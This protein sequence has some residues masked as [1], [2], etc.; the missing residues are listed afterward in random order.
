MIGH[1][2]VHIQ[3]F[4]TRSPDYRNLRFKIIPSLVEGPLPVRVLFPP[5][6][7]FVVYGNNLPISWRQENE[8]MSDRKKC[9]HLEATLDCMSNKG[10]RAATSLVKK[11]LRSVSVDIA[12][13]IG[14]ASPSDDTNDTDSELTACL[15]LLRLDHIDV[16]QCP[17]LPGRYDNENNSESFDARR[18][19]LILAEM[20]STSNL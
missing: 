11:Y 12:F 8:T 16:E 15:G 20:K 1:I 17:T 18:A 19:S 6:T 5:K 13:V 2:S 9:A 4:L 7:E 10:I 3:R 14:A